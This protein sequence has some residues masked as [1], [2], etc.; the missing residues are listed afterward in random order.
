MDSR[1]SAR[2]IS[3]LAQALAD[4]TRVAIL[5]SLAGG[6][7]CVCD[8]TDELVAAQSRLSFHLKILKDAGLISARPEGRM[9]YYALRRRPASD[10]G[11]FLRRLGR[12][13]KER[14]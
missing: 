6:E 3:T 1:P 13:A 8:L 4:P 12:T 7:R 10:L 5:E 2:R 9:T 11:A 14:A